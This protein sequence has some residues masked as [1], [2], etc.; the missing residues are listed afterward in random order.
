MFAGGDPGWTLPEGGGI[1]RRA[2]TNNPLVGTAGKD[3]LCGDN[4]NNTINGAGGNDIILGRG[5]NDRLTGGS[6]ND[7]LNGGPGNDTALFPGSKPVK[8]NL[9]TGFATGAGSDVLLGAEN[10]N[11][12]GAG[13]RLT[14]SAA[15]NVLVGLGGSDILNVRDGRAGDTVNGGAGTDNCVRDA[16]DTAK[17][18][19]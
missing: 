17:N 9:T 11:G 2:S 19:P 3:V 18:C 8:A 6:G 16:G 15:S 5:G 7:T 13:D 12:S 10:L 1:A 14:G 4:R